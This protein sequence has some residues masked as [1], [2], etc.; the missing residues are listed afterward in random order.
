MGC[1]LITGSRY[2]FLRCAAKNT[3]TDGDRTD[4]ETSFSKLDKKFQIF[5]K[6]C[7][8]KFVIHGVSFDHGF[9]IHFSPLRC[10]KHSN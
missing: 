4:E 10:E 3:R 6:N 9:S 2:I 8:E 1:L 7:I 5:E